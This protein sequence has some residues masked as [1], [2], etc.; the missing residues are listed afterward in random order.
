[1]PGNAKSFI[2]KLAW[3]LSAVL[4]LF[5]VKGKQALSN[6]LKY[7]MLGLYRAGHGCL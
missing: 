3:L 7:Q 4:R 6:V 2:S 5:L 1:M